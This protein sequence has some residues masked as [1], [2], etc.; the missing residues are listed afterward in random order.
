MIA[1][2]LNKCCTQ[3]SGVS[4]KAS[5]GL[6]GPGCGA[7]MGRRCGAARP[8]PQAPSCSVLPDFCCIFSQL[9]L[10]AAWDSASC[11]YCSSSNVLVRLPTLLLHTGSHAFLVSSAA[12]QFF[13]CD[14]RSV[15]LACVLCASLQLPSRQCFFF[16]IMYSSTNMECI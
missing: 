1:R 10:P 3:S 9:A 11:A 16:I 8:C 6:T 12:S 7:G 4:C 5:S 13:R 15:T 14:T 2:A